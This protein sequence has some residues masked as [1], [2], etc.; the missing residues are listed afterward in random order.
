MKRLTAAA[1][2]ILCT[3]ATACAH[4]AGQESA[5][6]IADAGVRAAGRECA[7]EG[8]PASLPP[9]AALAD[10]A[11]LSPWL[12]ALGGGEGATGEVVLSLWY[13][14]EG[15]NIRREVIAHSTTAEAADSIQKLV[16]ASLGTAP[17][18]ER[19]WGARLRVHV[20]PTPAF[21]LERREFCPP[22]PRNTRLEADM[23]G[24]IGTGVRYRNRQRERVELVEVTV[25]PAGY[26]A[27]AR[28]AREA[29]R[30][31]QLEYQVRD[32][33]RQFSFHPA[34][35]DGFPVYGSIRIPVRLRS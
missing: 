7:P 34:S 11:R 25:H 14:P 2:A 15:L 3:V 28:I 23:A 8:Y 17:V 4:G 9:L 32:L 5:V 24:Y 18:R 35:V 29:L 31:S 6:S 30:G 22:R 20:G 19:P 21:S 1:S 10:T 12:E 26:V 33:V 13:E 16:F 27:E